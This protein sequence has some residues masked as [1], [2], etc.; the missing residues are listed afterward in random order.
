[1]VF[2][3]KYF[4]ATFML[5]LVSK[6]NAQSIHIAVASNFAGPAKKIAERF[7]E[8]TGTE[9]ILSFGSS[10][11]LYAQIVNGAPYDV[12]LS[13]D[14]EKPAKLLEQGLEAEPFTY[15]VGR[16]V[17]WTKRADIDV[18]K[19]LKDG[20]FSF[21]AMANPDLAPYGKAAV[22]TQAILGMDPSILKRT[23]MGENVTQSYQ[24][25]QTGNA[26]L[27]FVA[28]SQLMI[29]GEISEGSA[30]IVPEENHAPILQDGILLN[31][32]DD[33]RA[34]VDF[35]QSAPIREIISI[36]GYEVPK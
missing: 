30:W 1:M 18:L 23:V 24:F 25:V 15:A 28:L 5:L 2:W 22:E 32:R 26:D 34:F 8:E 19:W 29:E 33:A 9:V 16:L 7:E 20:E 11:K 35:L 3:L 6:A 4:M 21:L 10:G 31:E 36:S 14:Q 27:G 13:A 17:L 12:F